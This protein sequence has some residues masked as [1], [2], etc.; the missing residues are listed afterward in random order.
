MSDPVKHAKIIVLE[1]PALDDG[2]FVQ[3]EIDLTGLSSALQ[4]EM[5]DSPRARRHV[6]L[7]GVYTEMRLVKGEKD[8]K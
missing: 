3:L 8:E 5:A 1:T 6:M 4:R 2:W 7:A